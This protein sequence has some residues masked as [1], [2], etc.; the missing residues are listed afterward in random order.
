MTQ[1]FTVAYCPDRIKA[2]DKVTRTIFR[3]K[4]LQAKALRVSLVRDAIKTIAQALVQNRIDILELYEVSDSIKNMPKILH[5]SIQTCSEIGQNYSQMFRANCTLLPAQKIFSNY[6]KT[7]SENRRYPDFRKFVTP[8]S[9]QPRFEL[10]FTRSRA[11]GFMPAL[12]PQVLQAAEFAYFLHVHADCQLVYDEDSYYVKYEG[13]EI[14]VKDGLIA[15]F[16]LPTAKRCD[17]IELVLSSPRIPW[18]Q[19]ESPVWLKALQ[20]LAYESRDSWMQEITPHLEVLNYFSSEAA[21]HL[22][23]LSKDYHKKKRVQECSEISSS[24]SEKPKSR[25]ALEVQL[26]DL[27]KV[28]ENGSPTEDFWRGLPEKLA[29]CGYPPWYCK[30]IYFGSGAQRIQPRRGKVLEKLRNEL[31]NL[32]G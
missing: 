13:F 24:R 12:Y 22:K 27:I 30:K 4:K 26:E 16:H 7:L 6:R 3:G 8:I 5:P 20:V 1:L 17:E 18:E 11:K 32:R 21:E 29:A 2:S 25:E 19:S 10:F 28:L 14:G 15:G 9:N 23:M 31:R